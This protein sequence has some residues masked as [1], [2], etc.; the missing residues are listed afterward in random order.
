MKVELEPGRIVRV[1]VSVSYNGSHLRL[2]T[3]A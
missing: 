2:E 3:E 1:G